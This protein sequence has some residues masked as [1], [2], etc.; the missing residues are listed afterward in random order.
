MSDGF[1]TIAAGERGLRYVCKVEGSPT[2]VVDQGQG[3]SIERS[4]ERSVVIGWAK[5]FTE[6][7]KSTRIIM[8]D[9]AGLGSSDQASPPR[10]CIEMV[11]DLRT[12]LLQARV[13][14]PYILVG[15][16]IGGFNA[17]VFA[18]RYLQKVV[19][20]VL[21]DSSHPDQLARLASILPPEPESAEAAPLRALRYGPDSTL[22][23]EAIDFRA[24]AMQAR[25]VTSI[26]LKPLVVVSQSP[27]ALGP[28]GIPLSVWE[29]MRIVVVPP[30]PT[31]APTLLPSRAR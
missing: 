12:V 7:Q 2:V 23:L 22:G 6:I 27:R 31:P 19:G 4:F 9:R 18:S 3:L 28:P 29:S 17:R 16:S 15:H 8:H 13:R 26:G 10:T 30:K 21:V 20:M 11:D 5:V 14:P 25:D 24:C 1:G